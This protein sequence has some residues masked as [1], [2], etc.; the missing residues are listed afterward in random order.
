MFDGCVIWTVMQIW[1]KKAAFTIPPKVL[2]SNPFIVYHWQGWWTGILCASVYY[3]WWPWERTG[4]MSASGPDMWIV[5]MDRYFSMFLPEELCGKIGMFCLLMTYLWG[6]L[7]V[8]SCCWCR[9]QSLL[10]LWKCLTLI[11]GHIQTYTEFSSG[12]TI[13]KACAL[14]IYMYSFSTRTRLK[15]N[16]L[17]ILGEE[18]S[19]ALF[20]LAWWWGF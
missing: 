6:R 11:R 15:E 5:S 13:V 8:C 1:H 7:A 19:C 17:W 16:W 20:W 3:L 10:I 4:S 9:V 14:H 12:G 18:A 2:Y